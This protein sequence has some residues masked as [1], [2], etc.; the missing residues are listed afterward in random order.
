MTL[1]TLML[2]L[3]KKFPDLIVY[4]I[5]HQGLKYDALNSVVY[6]HNEP[7]AITKIFTDDAIIDLNTTDQE[8]YTNGVFYKLEAYITIN[9]FTCRVSPDLSTLIIEP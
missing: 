6:H 3:A 7:L 4:H 8:L 9:D 1:E 5:D 2:R